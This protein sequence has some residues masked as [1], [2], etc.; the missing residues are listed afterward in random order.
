MGLQFTPAALRA[1][2][3]A[4]HWTSQDDSNG[5]APPE[6]LLGLLA[7]AESRAAGMLAAKGV[8]VE[9]VQR[10][11]PALK[12]CEQPPPERA[13]MF[14]A[15]VE[16]AFASALARLVDYPQPLTLA[17][18]HLL[19]GLA[20][21]NHELSCWLAEQGLAAEWLEAEIHRLAGHQPNLPLPL[22]LGEGTNHPLP[23]GEGW[24]EGERMASLRIIDAA[25]NRA[26]EA[27]RVLEDFSRFA[28]DDR[29]RTEQFKQL[30]HAL[31]AE[32]SRFSA[33]ELLAARDTPADVGTQL[34]ADAERTRSDLASVT[35]A[36]F[37]RLQES[38]R[39]LEEYGKTLD[40]DFGAALKQLRYRS[41]TL[42][43]T[44]AVEPLRRTSGGPGALPGWTGEGARPSLR[45]G[46][47]GEG[48]RPSLR[49]TRAKLYVLVDGRPTLEAF[50]AL[51]RDLIAS[52]VDVLQ[53]RDK[54][55]NDRELLARARRLA[56][57][58]A[59]TNTLFIMNDRADLAALARAD[60]VH[61]GQDELSVA[62]ARAIVGPSALVGV[63]THSLA[64]ARQAALDGADYIGVGPTFASTTKRFD[65]GQLTGLELLRAVAAEI[66]LPAF[67][68]GGIG[69]DNLHEVMAA[70][71]SRVAV[72]GAVLSAA[73]PA[74]A[75]GELRSTLGA[76]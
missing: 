21:A 18:E 62:E 47:T 23:L 43:K 14:S 59:G 41:Y 44:A 75:A 28:L 56:E 35:T 24:G 29:E 37:K 45:P 54:R 71:F 65:S 3:A 46:W 57:L 39:S 42:E 66:R 51:V 58:T 25:A 8:D 76:A 13:A 4:S 16:D 63:S 32:L 31:A 7:E 55:L 17:T 73:D 6:L 36:N 49:L 70:G 20:A 2:H 30:R 68:I 22:P 69:C 11:W 5:L 12:F 50:D 15:A 40:A 61:V 72:S 67:A 74:A 10:R 53:L 1:L 38:L 52:G 60:G 26:R 9:T 27:L 48:A 19:L 34:T 64:Q 33:A